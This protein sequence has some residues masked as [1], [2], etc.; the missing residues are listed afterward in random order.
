MTVA[1]DTDDALLVARLDRTVP[2][3]VRE[4]C[5]T[6][7]GAG[8][9]AVTVGGAVRDALLGRPADDW[10]VATSARPEQVVA[11]FPRTIPTG[12]AHG[13][14]TV[15]SGRAHERHAVEV[16]TYRGEG[17]Y[18]DARRPSSVTF[19]VPLDEDLARRDLVVNA[20]AYDPIARR[21]H[22]PFGGR[23]DL[24]ARRLRAVGDP[25]A[26]FTE[27][28]LRV[29]RAIRFTATLDFTLDAETEAAIPAALP[30]L[31]RVSRERIKVELDKLLAAPAPGHALEVAR[32]T[33]VLDRVAPEAVAGLERGADGLSGSPDD[34]AW[35][36]RLAW[37]ERLGDH[38]LRMAALL[39]GLSNGAWATEAEPRAFA[40]GDAAAAAAAD[41]A[42]RRLK[43]ANDERD[44]IARL[45]RVAWAGLVPASEVAVRR[46]LAA[47]GRA[48]GADAVALW[49]A[50]AATAPAMTRDRGAEVSALAETILARGDAL[51]AGE[52]AVTGAVLIAELGLAPGREIGRL[53]EL[54]LDAALDDPAVNTRER[55]LELCRA[56][57]A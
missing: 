37:I 46:L 44:R 51:A 50:R 45:V 24:A 34:W 55:L 25:V 53:L 9:Q 18:D 33:G 3:P 1:D 14:V 20:I 4:V 23:A 54:A 43:A 12:L 30:S 56:A 15:M 57:R 27:D 40:R 2:G 13:T 32:R 47:L 11:L 41:G 39:A 29:M 22:D 16:T 8:H 19:G 17:A 36:W 26:R 28:G 52:L 21:I 31:A 6:L 7:T 38:G 10:D 49:A 35:C 48:R 42:L 5:R